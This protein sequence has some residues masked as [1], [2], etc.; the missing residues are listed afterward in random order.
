M[1][2]IESH[3]GGGDSAIV[4]FSDG[5]CFNNGRK[6]ARAGYACVFPNHTQHTFSAPL[7]GPLVTNNRAEYTALLRA[8]EIS[9]TID[10]SHIK[11][12]HFYTDSMLLVNTATKWMGAWKRN[13]WRKA[14][15]NPV[16]N[17]DLVQAI[18]ARVAERPVVFHHVRAHT[19]KMDWKS[20]WNDVADKLAKE[21]AAAA[22]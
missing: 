22:K 21:A 2:Q 17:L 14:D 3:E 10:P 4:C 9:D 6:D 19:G 8:M 5:S 20:R 11:T 13:G 18:S 15:G 16:L 1:S 12:L 7:M